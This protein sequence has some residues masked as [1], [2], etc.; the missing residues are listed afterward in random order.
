MDVTF[1]SK[2]IRNTLISA[3]CRPTLANT[4][5]DGR[6]AAVPSCNSPRSLSATGAAAAETVELVLIEP[7]Q[8][9]AHP[10]RSMP[11][12]TSEKA[13]NYISADSSRYTNRRKPAP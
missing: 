1:A 10:G 12:R 2:R 8:E 11:I 6:D 9:L 3:T 4:N 7:H 5:C 13:S